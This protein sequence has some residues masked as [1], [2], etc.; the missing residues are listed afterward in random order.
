MLELV[1]LLL[2]LLLL[3]EELLLRVLLVGIALV[4]LQLLV[5]LSSSCG[6][7]VLSE[8]SHA[9]IDSLLL[10][11]LLVMTWLNPNDESLCVWA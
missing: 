11:L 3:E 1:V 10:M 7:C 5:L 2:P 4:L 8:M 6:I 9:F